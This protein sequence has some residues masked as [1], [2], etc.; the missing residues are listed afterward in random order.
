MPRERKE[1]VKY[2]VKLVSCWE[3]IDKKDQFIAFNITNTVYYGND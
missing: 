3:G 1:Q 2:R